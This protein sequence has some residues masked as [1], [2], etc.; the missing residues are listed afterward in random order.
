MSHS[1]TST[2]IFI[3][4]IKRDLQL[5]LRRKSDSLSALI[6]FCSCCQLVSS[7]DWS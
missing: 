1:A 3:G 6:F 4:I 2:S 7:R 5:A